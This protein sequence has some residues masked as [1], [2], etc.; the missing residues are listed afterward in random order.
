MRR[1]CCRYD[2]V[3]DA[4]AKVRRVL[5]DENLC[6][7]LT[8]AGLSGRVNLVGIVIAGDVG[9]VKADG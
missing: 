5:M 8:A 3:A 6:Q 7:R 1:G 4:A 9:V 2:D